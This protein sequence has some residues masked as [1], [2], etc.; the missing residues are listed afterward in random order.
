VTT[1][2]FPGC[3]FSNTYAW[4]PRKWGVGGKA[5]TSYG[6][7]YGN[8]AYR[9]Q[10]DW[11]DTES[12]EAVLGKVARGV[13]ANVAPMPMEEAMVSFFD[14]PGVNDMLGVMF[15]RA[16]DLRRIGDAPA[17]RFLDVFDDENELLAVLPLFYNDPAEA[18]TDLLSGTQYLESGT[19]DFDDVLGW[20]TLDA[21][22]D[23]D[24]DD[25]SETGG[26][27]ADTQHLR[28]IMTS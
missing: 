19:V 23:T 24:A 2:T 3:W 11:R 14:H 9:G 7:G 5:D 21:D 28:N 10:V 20:Y 1:D 22:D 8:S 16:R 13:A 15:D 27:D 18:E 26:F 12:N 6:Y 25:E 17:K 4:T